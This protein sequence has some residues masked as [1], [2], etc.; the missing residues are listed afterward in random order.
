MAKWCIPDGKGKQLCYDWDDWV[1][2]KE[3]AKSWTE[4]A[5]INKPNP[6]RK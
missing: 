2:N 4:D 6:G 5:P 3:N 1:K